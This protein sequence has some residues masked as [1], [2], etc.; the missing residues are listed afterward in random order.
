MSHLVHISRSPAPAPV[1]TLPHVPLSSLLLVPSSLFAAVDDMS[2]SFVASAFGGVGEGDWC[3]RN[4]AD[5]G[6]KEVVIPVLDVVGDVT[7]DP[8]VAPAFVPTA[9][10]KLVGRR[11]KPL[12]VVTGAVF[13][14]STTAAA[15]TV[16]PDC[17][18]DAAASSNLN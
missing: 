13:V 18:W 16:G 14:V 17:S 15:V 9:L 2:R 10:F 12:T 6:R 8:V 4:G 11:T 1:P 5:T 3:G 7:G